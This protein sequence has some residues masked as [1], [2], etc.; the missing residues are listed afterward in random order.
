MKPVIDSQKVKKMFARGEL[1]YV[2]PQ[3]GYKYSMTARCPR[4]G[5]FGSIARVDKTG[6]VLSDITFQCTICSTPFKVHQEDIYI[7]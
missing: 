6:Q 7:Q 4:D 3:T 2:D 1:F 5:G